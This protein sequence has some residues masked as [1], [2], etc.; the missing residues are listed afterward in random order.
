M[1]GGPDNP[2]GLGPEAGPQPKR[3]RGAASAPPSRARG[4]LDPI[5]EDGPGGG[6]SA[7]VRPPGRG[8]GSRTQTPSFATAR[9]GAGSVPKEGRLPSVSSRPAS[10]GPA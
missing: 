5:A 7:R 10:L 9:S 1:S 2:P 4:S 3:P 6:A 8:S